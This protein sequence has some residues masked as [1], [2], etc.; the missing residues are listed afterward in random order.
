ML[1]KE[2]ADR[3]MAHPGTKQ[4]GIPTVLLRSC[5][6]VD[7]L[8]TLKPFE[9]HP[10]PKIDSVVVKMVFSPAVHHLRNLPEYNYEIVKTIVRA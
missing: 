9:F 3:L 8:M 5:A 2:V 10:R 7:K 6:T 4:Y 1:Q